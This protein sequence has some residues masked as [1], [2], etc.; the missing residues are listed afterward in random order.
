MTITFDSDCMPK[1]NKLIVFGASQMFLAPAFQ[2]FRPWAIPT[3]AVH[4][5]SARHGANCRPPLPAIRA[6][7]PP[8]ART[9]QNKT[10]DLC[11]CVLNQLNMIKHD[12]I[13]STQPEMIFIG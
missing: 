12:L 6:V 4:R 9:E 10:P 3:P 11:V 7:S 5:R 2:P 8:G 13:K 1:L